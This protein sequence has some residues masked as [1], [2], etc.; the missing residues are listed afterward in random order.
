MTYETFLARI[1]EQIID[2]LITV[3]ALAAFVLFVFGVFEF[4]KGADND[5]A[6]K[7]GQRHIIWGLVGLAILFGA[8]TITTLLES[9]ANSLFS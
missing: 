1:S 9:L 8:K 2:P 6:R 4:I 5:E 7:T 3:L